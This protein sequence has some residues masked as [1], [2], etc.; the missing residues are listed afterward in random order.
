MLNTQPDL[1]YG[2]DVVNSLSPSHRCP[3]RIWPELRTKN[4]HKINEIRKIN[5]KIN[6]VLLL[7]SSY[8]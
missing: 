1:D 5:H 2:T 3:G 7:L 6:N 8:H 4:A